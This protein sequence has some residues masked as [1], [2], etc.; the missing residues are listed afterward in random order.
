[1]SRRVCFIVS[2][3]ATLAS[4]VAQADNS[5]MCTDRPTKANSATCTVAPGFWQIESD[6]VNFTHNRPDGVT[7]DTWSIPNATMKYGIDDKSDVQVSWAA[8]NSVKTSGGGDR[9]VGVGD[10]YLRYKRRLTDDSSSVNVSIFPYVKIPTAKQGIGN[11]KVEGGLI[12]PISFSLPSDYTLTF[13]PEVDITM[14]ADQSGYHM[15]LVNPINLSHAITSKFSVAGELWMAN[16]FDPDGTTTQ[17]TADFA[18]IY[19]VNNNLQLDI[20]TNIGLNKYAPDYQV[21]TGISARF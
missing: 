17:Y 20:G 2:F 21:Y 7:T 13:G 4:A 6:M 14:D 3:F 16:N 10:V 19:L 12:M 18:A 5:V 1:M 8:Y 15:T 11:H 9:L